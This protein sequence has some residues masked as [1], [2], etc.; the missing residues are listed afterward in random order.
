MDGSLHYKDLAWDVRT[1]DMRDEAMQKEF[2]HML[3]DGL[4]SPY[5]VI[6]EKDHIHCEYDAKG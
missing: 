5:Q 6:L 3:A 2:R 1:R 4:L